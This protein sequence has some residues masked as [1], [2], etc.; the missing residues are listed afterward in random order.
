MSENN[1]LKTIYSENRTL[2]TTYPGKFIKNIHIKDRKYK[3]NT[4]RLGQG[5][6]NF[7]KNITKVPMNMYEKD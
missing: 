7:F 2:F 5:N 6:A 3:G 1:Y 4:V